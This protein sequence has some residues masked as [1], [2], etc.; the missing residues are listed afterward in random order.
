MFLAA[1]LSDRR[2]TMMS[3]RKVDSEALKFDNGVM[4]F[5]LVN[6]L[7]AVQKPFHIGVVRPCRHFACES[8]SITPYHPKTCARPRSANNHHLQQQSGPS[9]F[10]SDCFIWQWK[11]W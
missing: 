1:G 8:L 6:V 2:A 9:R 11:S 5:P 7:I 3:P 10:S 4:L